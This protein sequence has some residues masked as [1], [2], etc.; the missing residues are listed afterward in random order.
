MIKSLK[1]KIKGASPLMMHSPR[2]IN[3][4]DPLKV[5]IAKLTSIRSNK[6]SEDQ[7]TE[8]HRLE[9]MMGLYLDEK[10]GPYVPGIAIEACIRDGARV[11]RKG[12]SIESGVFVAEDVVPLGYK[13]PRDPESLWADANFVDQRRATVGKAGVLRTRPIFHDWTLEFGVNYDPDQVNKD[14]LIEFVKT[15]GAVKGLLEHRPRFGRFTVESAKDGKG[16]I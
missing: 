8:I 14:D 13:G 5:E 3:P 11:S 12:K 6:R 2:G 9:F 10:V 1:F 15:A 7:E 4:R 16:I